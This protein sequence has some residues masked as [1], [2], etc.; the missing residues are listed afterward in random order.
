MTT[1][2][3]FP[4]AFALI[5]LI[6]F[7]AFAGIPTCTSYGACVEVINNCP[8]P[9]YMQRSWIDGSYYYPTNVT[10]VNGNGDKVVLDITSWTD[11]YGARL[12]AWWQNPIGNQSVIN[13]YNIFRDWIDIQYFNVGG[14]QY[15][16]GSS[17]KFYFALPVHMKPFNA[18]KD[19]PYIKPIGQGNIK[20]FDVIKQCPTLFKHAPPFGTCV[21]PTALCHY[22]PNSTICTGLYSIIAECVSDGNCLLP[23]STLDYILCDS[24]CQQPNAEKWC[25]AINRGIYH[26]VKN[27][28]TQNNT[29][30]FYQNEPYNIFAK[31]LHYANSNMTNNND[32]QHQLAFGCDDYEGQTGHSYDGKCDTNFLS[33]TFCPSG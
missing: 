15:W 5:I 27:G 22:K 3:L 31:W 2:K 11:L 28:G 23:M 30:I 19:C 1:S 16:S 7:T 25:A 6:T 4:F 32:Y 18:S 10:V 24:W 8:F 33:V 29:D 21:S 14:M 9:L 20:V 12:F 17:A 26:H 13:N